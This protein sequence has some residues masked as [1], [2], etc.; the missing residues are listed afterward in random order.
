MTESEA[1][2][3]ARLLALHESARLHNHKCIRCG[4]KHFETGNVIAF[5]NKQ[6]RL[7]FVCNENPKC[8]RD[9]ET[10]IHRN[11]KSILPPRVM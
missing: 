7:E 8:G 1:V 5:R 9:L 6:E 11:Q 4:A 10:L 3:F 2:R